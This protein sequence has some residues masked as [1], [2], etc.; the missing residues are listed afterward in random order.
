MQFSGVGRDEL[1]R[2][3]P[4]ATETE[5]HPF[6]DRGGQSFEFGAGIRGRRRPVNGRTRKSQGP[7]ILQTRGGHSGLRLRRKGSAKDAFRYD[8]RKPARA[9]GIL[10]VPRDG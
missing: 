8:R 1:R 6:S 9:G 2:Y 4:G 5:L 7:P 10:R 3:E